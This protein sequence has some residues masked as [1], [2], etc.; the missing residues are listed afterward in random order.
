MLS[1]YK[2]T[3]YHH[4]SLNDRLLVTGYNPLLKRAFIKYYNEITINLLFVM[5][6]NKRKILQIKAT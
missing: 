2:S 3:C 1:H 6:I 5:I 4:Y